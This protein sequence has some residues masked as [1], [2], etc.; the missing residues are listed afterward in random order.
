MQ[1]CDLVEEITKRVGKQCRKGVNSLI[2]LG[3]WT[4]WKHQN[5]CVIDG[6]SPSVATSVRNLELEGRL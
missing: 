2:I 3:A 4:L 6:D 5:A 1:L